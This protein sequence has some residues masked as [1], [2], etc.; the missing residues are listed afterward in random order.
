MP[1]TA[2]RR[3]LLVDDEDEFREN[4]ARLLRRR[5]FEVDTA[6]DGHLA[7]GRLDPARPYHVAL[8][9]VRMPG[10]DGIATLECLRREAPEIEVIMLTGHACIE[11]G[12]AAIRLGAF[13]YLQKPCDLDDLL[14]KLDSA[15]R[16]DAMR[17]R[18]VLWPRH[19]AAEMTFCT[20]RRLGPEAPL[21][22]VLAF[23]DLDRSP[24]AAD[25]LF[26]IGA[27]DRLCGLISRQDLIDA[28]QAAQPQR[29]ISWEDLRRNGHWL[30]EI[31][32]GALVRNGPRVVCAAPGESLVALARRMMDH[33]IRSM[34]V[35]DE[36][37][38]TGIVRLRD[39]LQFIDPDGPGAPSSG[40]DGV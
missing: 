35:V 22:E 23:F 37:R 15:A 7:L 39:V 9:D 16:A 6:G 17:R 21:S 30:P 27:D 14:Q 34:P 33:H 13:D 4:L 5:G 29:R 32:A 11:D 18:P 20:L 25:T 40:A 19:T 26:V 8:L 3:L 36:G 2:T 12:A 38:V 31:R 24:Q 10:M 1:N 28:A